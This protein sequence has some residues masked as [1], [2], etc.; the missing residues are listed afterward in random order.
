MR[1]LGYL[2]RVLATSICFFGFGLGCLLIAPTVLPVILLWPASRDMRRRRFRRVVS[3]G[4]R[5]LLAVVRP[6]GIGRIEVQ[7]R[8]RLK[9]ADGKLVLATHP[10]FIDAVVLLSLIPDADCVVKSTILRNPFTRWFAVTAD[11]ISNRHDDPAA[12]IDSCV[13][14]VKGGQALVLFPEGTRS[15]PGRPLKLKRGA[16]QIAVRG[17]FEIL[18]VVIHCTPPTMLKD[19]FWYQ[20][21]ERPWVMTVKV[22]A[23][24]KLKDI[25]PV[26]SLPPGVAVRR[27]TQALQTYFQ[28][29]LPRG[30]HA[31]DIFPTPVTEP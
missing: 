24:R 28:Q 10:S 23:P 21:P 20:V 8:E 18:P 3:M 17:D 15:V 16:M 11:Y 26:A 30:E 1:R 22:C 5:M 19:T 7:G 12:I 9:Q 29:Q 6:M 13:E 31:P 25:A 27:L 2:Y 14:A 4:F